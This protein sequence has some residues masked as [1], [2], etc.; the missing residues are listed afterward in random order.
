MQ[1]RHP[2]LKGAFGS[3]DGLNLAVQ[4]S[5]DPNLENATYSSWLHSHCVSSVFVFSPNGEL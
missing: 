5:S 2:R 4:T 1:G 3:M